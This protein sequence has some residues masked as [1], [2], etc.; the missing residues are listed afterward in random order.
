MFMLSGLLVWVSIIS[1]SWKYTKQ[2]QWKGLFTRKI[3]SFPFLSYMG[4]GLRYNKVKAIERDEAQWWQDARG[5]GLEV[6]DFQSLT[7]LLFHRRWFSD[8]VELTKPK[9][10]AFAAYCLKPS[11]YFYLR[12]VTQRWGFPLIFIV[13][14]FDL[15]LNNFNLLKI[16]RTEAVKGI[17]NKKK[18]DR[19]TF[20]ILG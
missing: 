2:R 20:I 11:E 1:M 13:C 6:P 17:L 15:S 18:N 12:F 19:L 3:H 16:H 8:R 9:S 7:H 5:S 14:H 4:M 10:G